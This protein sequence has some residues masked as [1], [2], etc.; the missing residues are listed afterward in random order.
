M[1]VPDLI[2]II[3]DAW[4]DDSLPPSA[5]DTPEQ[6]YA[7]QLAL[8]ATADQLYRRLLVQDA[9]ALSPSQRSRRTRRLNE[10]RQTTA[11]MRSQLHKY[12]SSS[13]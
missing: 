3:C 11:D 2:N 10:L 9:T 12:A 6:V 13:K 4:D 1:F 5:N 8:V 7:R